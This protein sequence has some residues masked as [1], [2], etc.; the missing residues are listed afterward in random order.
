MSR[1]GR[2][3]ISPAPSY[4]SAAAAAALAKRITPSLSSTSTGCAVARSIAARKASAPTRRPRKSIKESK[5]AVLPRLAA[6][7]SDARVPQVR[8]DRVDTLVLGRAAI[9]AQRVEDARYVLLDGGLAD[10][11]GLG[12]PSVRLPLGHG[13]EDVALA[14]AELTEW[15]LGADTTEHSSHHPWIER[16]AARRDTCHRLREGADVPHAFLQHVALLI[17]LRQHQDPRVGTLAPQLDG[18]PQPV[19]GTGRRHLD[20]HDR[21]VGPVCERP[22]QEVLRVTD[23]QD[24]VK[25]GLDEN[26]RDALAHQHVVFTDD[27][28]RAHRHSP[29][30]LRGPAGIQP[31]AQGLPHHTGGLRVPVQP[32]RARGTVALVVSEHAHP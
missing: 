3:T 23:L 31:R 11:E 6:D 18:G 19:V 25:A 29:C 7:S 14:R 9:E 21:N 1:P 13:G 4:P 12:D 8:Q 27:N 24:D 17:E 26:A 32:E 2:P 16:A 20:V 28:A 5:V 10:D 22:A 30:S 15:S